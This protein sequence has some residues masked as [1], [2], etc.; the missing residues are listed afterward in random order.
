MK[1]P[2][3]L[4]LSIKGLLYYNIYTDPT[5]DWL[6]LDEFVVTST[7]WSQRITLHLVTLER[8]IFR[9]TS[10]LRGRKSRV[11]L[12]EGGKKGDEISYRS[13]H[14]RSLRRRSHGFRLHLPSHLRG[15]GRGTRPL[16]PSFCPGGV[17]SPIIW[18]KYLS[19]PSHSLFLRP[20]SV[21]PS[22]SLEM[23][24][25]PNT[26]VEPPVTRVNPGTH[27]GYQTW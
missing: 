21:T 22:F 16:S 5:I 2:L 15:C 12:K 11:F 10:F 19:I 26:D 9:Q 13:H 17:L 1:I 24:V 8:V 6:F 3:N 18:T 27:S 20:Y 23:T 25:V 7:W 4:D 14:L